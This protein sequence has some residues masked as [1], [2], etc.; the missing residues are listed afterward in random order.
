MVYDTLGDKVLKGMSSTKLR[1]F[2]CGT[3]C[4]IFLGILLILLSAMIG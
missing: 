2:S 1:T 4:L 3:V